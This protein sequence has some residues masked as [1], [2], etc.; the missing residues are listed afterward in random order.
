VHVEAFHNVYSLISFLPDLDAKDPGFF[1][2][3]R[4]T[5]SRRASWLDFVANSSI[6]M[7]LSTSQASDRLTPIKDNSKA[8]EL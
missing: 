5:S 4:M 8:I 6:S 7:K 2:A 1:A 3:L